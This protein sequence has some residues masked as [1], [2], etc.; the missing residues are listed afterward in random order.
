MI[1]DDRKILVFTYQTRL[2][3]PLNNPVRLAKQGIS[4]VTIKH[5]M[6][7]NEL[8]FAT[9]LSAHI[10]MLNSTIAN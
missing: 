7:F 8:W 10:D 2:H 1:S 3:F 9:S 4:H 6:A 5:V